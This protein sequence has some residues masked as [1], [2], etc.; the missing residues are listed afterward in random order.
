MQLYYLTS[1]LTSRPVGFF[2][3]ASLIWIFG[4]FYGDCKYFLL[5]LCLPGY[6]LTPCCLVPRRIACSTQ[7]NQNIQL[8][9]QSDERITKMEG[10][11]DLVERPKKA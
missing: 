5:M 2:L 8:K 11:Q 3:R 7:L 9:H 4:L 1:L 6:K 10:V